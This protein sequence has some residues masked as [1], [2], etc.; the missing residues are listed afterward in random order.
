M[1]KLIRNEDITT[2]GFVETILE[3]LNAPIGVTI[4]EKMIRILNQAEMSITVKVIITSGF[5]KTILV[6]LNTPI[7]VVIVEKIIRI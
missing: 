1:E 5:A 6:I 3:V 4:I 7:S 2:S